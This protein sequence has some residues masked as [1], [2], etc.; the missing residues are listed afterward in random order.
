M[1]HINHEKSHTLKINNLENDNEKY[2][3]LYK[4][5]N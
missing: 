4:E 5:Q 1:K 2:V 3:F